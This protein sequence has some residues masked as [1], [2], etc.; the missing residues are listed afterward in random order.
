MKVESSL[1]ALQS[2]FAPKPAK[3]DTL[4]DSPRGKT[5]VA[6]ILSTIDQGRS[7]IRQG[8]VES[9]NRADTYRD[10][11]TLTDQLSLRSQN[12]V[13]AYQ[14]ISKEQQRGEIQLLLGVDTFV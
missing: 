10:K 1:G 4:S 11:Q 3:S 2:P 6:G 8:T 14:S 5:D 7:A 9:F 13:D 12:A